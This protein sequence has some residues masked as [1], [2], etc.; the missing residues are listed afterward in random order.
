ML[1]APM[2]PVVSLSARNIATMENAWNP[3]FVNASPDMVGA[4]AQNLVLQGN[5]VRT[6]GMIVPA[7]T[8][9]SATL[10]PANVLV[11]QDGMANNATLNVRIGPTVKAAR[12]VATV[13]T[14]AVVTTFQELVL[15]HQD[16]KELYAMSRAH[17]ALMGVNA[18][19]RAN[20][21]TGAHAT[22]SM[23]NAI[24]RGDGRGKCAPILVLQGLLEWIA[25]TAVTATT[26]LCATMSVDSATVYQGFK[27]KSVKLNA[28]T[29]NMVCNAR[30]AAVAR[31]AERATPL[32]VP[33]HV[34][35][36][37]KASIVAKGVA[38]TPRHMDPIVLSSVLVTGTTLSYA[39]PG[40]A[41]V[42]A[43]LATLG[44]IAIDLVPCTLMVAIVVMCAIAKT[45]PFVTQPTESALAHRDSSVKNATKN[46]PNLFMEKAANINAN[47][48]MVQSVMPHRVNATVRPVGLEFIVT[49]LVRPVITAK[50]VKRN[51]TAK[52][53]QLATISPANVNAWQASR[54]AIVKCLVIGVATGSAV[55]I[56]AIVSMPT[57]MGAIQS[58]ESASAS[59]DGKVFNVN[60]SAKLD[61]MVQIVKTNAI[62]AKMV[63][64]ASPNQADVFANKVSLDPDAI[65]HVR[66]VSMESDV[67]KL[68]SLALQVMGLAII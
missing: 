12:N 8:E 36:V 34:L 51:A 18:N 2:A 44:T 3:T 48:K 65:D 30:K 31:M 5:G 38:K 1:E 7:S 21:K 32:T 27:E 47:A 26:E 10:L 16:G 28:R 43:S 4:L 62:A 49:R 68:A 24:V 64:L 42:F 55:R 19:P 67:S 50:I 60:Q 13:K 14:E 37:G 59:R 25:R 9:P 45:T 66:K 53:E 6:A 57:P 52:M 33:A 46:A 40:L 61:D 15:A 63:A 58:V 54:A 35:T 39:I 56:A 11:H 29:A 17:L 23:A 22:Q 41:G 20:A